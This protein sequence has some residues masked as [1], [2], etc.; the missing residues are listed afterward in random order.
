MSDQY[1]HKCPLCAY[2]AYVGAYAVKCT[3][4]WCKHYEPP[5]FEYPESKEVSPE[6]REALVKGA[7]RAISGLAAW[8]PRYADPDDYD[9][10]DNPSD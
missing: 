4:V 2:P 10:D 6:L 7:A 9:L 1:P 8:L 5:K 3:N